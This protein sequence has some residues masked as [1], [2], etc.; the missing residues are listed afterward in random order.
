MT[1]LALETELTDEQRDY[2]G[3]VRAASRALLDVINDLL[4]FAKIDAGR[5]E[6]D[7]HAFALRQ[8]LDEALRP[9][10]FRARGKGL[11]F[12]WRV[13]DDV[14]DKLL[15]DWPR[16]RQVLLNLTGNALKFT[17]RGSVTVAVGMQEPDLQTPNAG[18][19]WPTQPA[20]RMLQFS[21]VDT[22]IGIPSD[23]LSLVFEPFVQADGSTTRKYGGTGLGLSISTKLAA[24][25]G[26][27]VCAAS[28]PGVGSTFTLAAP[29]ELAGAGHEHDEDPSRTPAPPSCRPLHLLIAEDNPVNQKLVLRLLEKHGHTGEVAADGR[30]A[31]GALARGSFDG[32]LMDI[33]MPQMDGLEVTKHFRAT[34]APGR[35]LPIVAMTAHARAG[36]HLRCLEAG[37]D[38]YLAKPLD[39]GELLRTLAEIIAPSGTSPVRR[40]RP[41]PRRPRLEVFNAPV[42]LDRVGGDRQLLRELGDLCLANIPGWLADVRS[43]LAARD[44]VR[45]RRA[46]HTIKGA[47]GSIGGDEAAAASARLEERGRASLFEGIGPDLVAVEQ[48]LARLESVLRQVEPDPPVHKETTP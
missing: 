43:A 38:A 47:V 27:R 46:A 18:E 6:L 4:D 26:G 23:K 9:L 21:V 34:E 24:L 5:L 44:A 32:V 19:A 7:P 1:E 29:V 37:M 10:T 39:A 16:L 22:G 36:D 42:A 28:T 45:L 2:L 17:E 20:S 13:D 14:P 12:C 40:E 30:A 3:M 15:A 48:A 25:M 11:D 33:Q 41:A 35:H 31:L 8:S